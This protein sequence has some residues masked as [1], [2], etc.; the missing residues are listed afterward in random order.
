MVEKQDAVKDQSSRRDTALRAEEGLSTE[1]ASEPAQKSLATPAHPG[2]STHFHRKLIRTGGEFECRM[3]H[4]LQALPAW[5]D[6]SG[7]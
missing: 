2:P 1:R 3:S 4:L 7:Y 6:D 5:N